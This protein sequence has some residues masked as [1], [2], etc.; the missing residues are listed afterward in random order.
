MNIQSG[1][2]TVA[3]DRFYDYPESI[4]RFVL[5]HELGHYVLQSRNELDVDRWALR[6]YMNTGGSAKEAVFALTRVLS[7]TNPEH[8]E[9]LYH[10]LDRVRH[11]DY[12]INGNIN[13]LKYKPE[14]EHDLIR[15]YPTRTS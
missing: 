9:R 4:R 7:F 11:Y 2:I 15:P 5:L 6:Q 3:K 8:R 13:A 12:H 14:Y 1:V 10:Q